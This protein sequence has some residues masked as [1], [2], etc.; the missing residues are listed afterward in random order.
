MDVSY[1]QSVDLTCPACGQ[2]FTAEVWLIVDGHARPDLL[3]RARDDTLH[4]LPCSN[5]AHR[6]DVDA[7]LL[8][9]LPERE[10]PLLFAP[11]RGTPPEENRAHAGQLVGMMRET[12]DATWQDTWIAGGVPGVER[13]MVP[14]ALS[15][16]PEAAMQQQQTQAR[17][18]QQTA[19]AAREALNTL[20]PDA[21]AQAI[22]TALINGD[23]IGLQPGDLDAGFFNTLAIMQAEAEPGSDRAARLDNVAERLQKAQPHLNPESGPTQVL[24]AAGDLGKALLTFFDAGDWD[25]KQRILEQHPTLLN[26]E[27]ETLIARLLAVETRDPNRQMV[28]AHRDLLRRCR[29]LGIPAAFAERTH[30]H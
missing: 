20:S 4:K 28:I 16:D 18:R 15:D 19:V 12:L 7:P 13:A 29:A 30:N 24:T 6:G 26:D 25:A 5:C 14:V 10:P 9:Y 11:A 3:A 1:A 2:A 27:A 17:Q 22:V 8:L 21:R 23:P